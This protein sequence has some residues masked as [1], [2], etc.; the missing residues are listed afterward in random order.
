MKRGKC[1]I[2]SKAWNMLQN[3]L[4]NFSLFVRFIVVK[5]SLHLNLEILRNYLKNMLSLISV[6]MREPLS[7]SDGLFHVKRKKKNMR[8][9]ELR[10][11]WEYKI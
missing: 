6:F 11:W 5:S 2:L 10:H 9:V 4:I 1:K 7:T 3:I 8:K